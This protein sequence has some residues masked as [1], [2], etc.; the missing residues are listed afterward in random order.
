MLETT[1]KEVESVEVC[2]SNPGG[3]LPRLIRST[4]FSNEEVLLAWQPLSKEV[5][6]KESATTDNKR[7]R[8]NRPIGNLTP[9]RF[10]TIKIKCLPSSARESL[11]LSRLSLPNSHH[12]KQYSEEHSK[13]MVPRVDEL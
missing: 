13:D 10:L 5:L 9:R 12:Y 11:L 1:S 4:S 7:D 3:S 6:K 2:Q 8:E